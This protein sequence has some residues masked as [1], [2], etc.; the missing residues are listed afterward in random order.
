MNEHSFIQFN[1]SLIDRV[2]MQI[3][4]WIRKNFSFQTSWLKSR[5]MILPLLIKSV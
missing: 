1:P 3:I 2:S 4:A 5:T